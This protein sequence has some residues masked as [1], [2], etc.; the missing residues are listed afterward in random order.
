MNTLILISII[1]I[2]LLY[3]GLYKA[4]KALLPVSIIGL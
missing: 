4:K 1:P 2:V 3:L